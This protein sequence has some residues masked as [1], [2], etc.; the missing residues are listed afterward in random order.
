LNWRPRAEAEK[1][2][3]AVPAIFT[4]AGAA[5]SKIARHT[6]TP[7]DDCHQ[8]AFGLFPA[9]ATKAGGLDHKSRMEIVEQ[10]NLVFC[11]PCM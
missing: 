9:Q 10:F 8:N 5:R 6:A 2:N 3:L 4:L 7:S 11:F 1:Y